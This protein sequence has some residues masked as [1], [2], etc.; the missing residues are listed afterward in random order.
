MTRGE[1]KKKRKPS[2][3]FTQTCLNHRVFILFS[4]DLWGFFFSGNIIINGKISFF[5]N[6]TGQIFKELRT[7]SDSTERMLLHLQASS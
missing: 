2:T 5:I 6:V 3:K 7:L 4:L 1:K